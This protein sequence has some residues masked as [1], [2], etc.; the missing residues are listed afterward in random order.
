MKY[1]SGYYLQITRH[2]F[3][4]EKFQHFSKNAKWL[5][6]VLCELEH[7]FTSEGKRKRTDW[8]YRSD[9]DLAKDS[10]MSLATTKRVK[11][12]LK[13]NKDIIELWQMHWKDKELGKKSEKHVTAFRILN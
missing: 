10:Q 9:K 11:Q 2:L 12:E 8:F 13:N 4:G 1:K 7:R 6:A 5:Y 3:H